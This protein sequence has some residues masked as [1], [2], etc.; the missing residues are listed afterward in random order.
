MKV[1]PLDL[2]RRDNL[3]RISGGLFQI[4]SHYVDFNEPQGLA[5]GHAIEFE[6]FPLEHL[7]GG[8]PNP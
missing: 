2:F 1:Q 6:G 7:L 4:Q 5:L 8:K 3:L